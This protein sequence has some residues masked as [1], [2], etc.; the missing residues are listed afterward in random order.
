MSNDLTRSDVQDQDEPAAAGRTEMS[1]AGAESP[2]RPDT[3][4]AA[5]AAN[6]SPQPPA[7]RYDPD[8]AIELLL[9]AVREM[10]LQRLTTTA[11]GVSARMRQIDPDFTAGAAGFRSFRAL[12]QL[13]SERGLISVDA[14]EGASDF[15][16][17]LGVQ[18][19]PTSPT[20][21]AGVASGVTHTTW[22]RH[23]FWRALTDWSQTSYLYNR[24]T[25]RTVATSEADFAD[26]ADAVSFPVTSQEQRQQWIRDFS[27]S[28]APEFRTTV[29]AKLGEDPSG[30]SFDAEV[31]A[32]P[33]TRRRWEG[34]LRSRLLDLT[35]QWAA[36]HGVPLTDVTETSHRTTAPVGS[37]S[38]FDQQAHLGATEDQI[39]R[40]ILSI[41]ARMPLRDLLSIPIPVEYA[42]RR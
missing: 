22:L 29:L 36:A 32:R 28:L 39:R 5:G 20:P 8:A 24:R 10:Q 6:S 14:P 33:Q 21:S 30:A 23:D 41:M 34:F 1:S 11:A 27:D 17:S 4:S 26:T 25:R 37:L 12:L 31:R 2:D 15:V 35:Q 3:S 18:P 7:V 13:A 40:E 19:I 9:E 42:L 38:H 16:V